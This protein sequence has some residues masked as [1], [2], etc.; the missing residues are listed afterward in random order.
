[1]QIVSGGGSAMSGRAATA[2]LRDPVIFSKFDPHISG[3]GGSF[4]PHIM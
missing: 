1:M 2:H 3:R 4:G